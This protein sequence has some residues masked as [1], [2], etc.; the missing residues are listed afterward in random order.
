M[1]TYIKYTLNALNLFKLIWVC[2]YN[3]KDSKRE[4][5]CTNAKRTEKDSK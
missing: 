2:I 4:A 3:G 5:K 1:Y